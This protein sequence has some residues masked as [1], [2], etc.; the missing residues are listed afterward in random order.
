LRESHEQPQTNEGK[1]KE[2]FAAMQTWCLAQF[3]RSPLGVEN[4]L[5]HLKTIRVDIV[6]LRVIAMCGGAEV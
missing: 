3:K 2:G 6:R 5:V 1:P 4:E